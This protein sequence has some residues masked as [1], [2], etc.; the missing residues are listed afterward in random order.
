MIVGVLV[1]ERERIAAVLNQELRVGEQCGVVV[2]QV[3]AMVVTQKVTG[4]P[5]HMQ[6]DG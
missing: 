6:A 5:S 4:L 1:S 2:W 3:L